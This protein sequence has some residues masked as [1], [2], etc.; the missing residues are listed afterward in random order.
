MK[1][2]SHEIAF[3]VLNA[4]FSESF[5]APTM[6][7]IILATSGG[8]TDYLENV[9][10]ND[11]QDQVH[12]LAAISSQRHH[13]QLAGFKNWR[14]G[15]ENIKMAFQ[16]FKDSGRNFGHWEAFTNGTYKE[17][18]PLAYYGVETPF[19][20]LRNASVV[21]EENAE[22]L[23]KLER[24]IVTDSKILAKVADE[25]EKLGFAMSTLSRIVSEIRTFFRA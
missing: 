24:T 15:F 25:S 3:L 1:L 8:E 20:P 22:V 23:E 12:G 19:K 16:L 5:E 10:Y 2:S 11:L 13:D 21:S 14:D 7:A 18:M 9:L 4:G 17:Y 6:V